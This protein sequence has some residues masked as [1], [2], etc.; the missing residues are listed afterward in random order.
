MAEHTAAV[1]ET[2]VVTAVNS[3]LNRG[4]A[5]TYVCIASYAVYLVTFDYCGEI[6][7]IV[8]TRDIASCPTSISKQPVETVH[9]VTHHH[10]GQFAQITIRYRL[11]GIVFE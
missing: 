1:D 9:L 8:V 11:H 6:T 4:A 5:P 2:T 10:V 3:W 7:V